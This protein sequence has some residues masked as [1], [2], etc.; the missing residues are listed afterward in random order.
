M[1]TLFQS[2][3]LV[4]LHSFHFSSAL[5]DKTSFLIPTGGLGWVFHNVIKEEVEG[6]AGGETDT[7][8]SGQV[9]EVLSLKWKGSNKACSMPR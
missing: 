4:V 1:D 9:V 7:S 8:K 6:E 5:L 3:R 2:Q